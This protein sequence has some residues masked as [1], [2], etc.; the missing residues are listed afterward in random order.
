VPLLQRPANEQ[1]PQFSPDGK[2]VAYDS[3]ET[4][5]A[6]IWVVAMPPETTRIQ[7]S[8]EG[9]TQARWSRDGKELFWISASGK[10]MAAPVT[11]G[12]AF[13]HGAAKQLFPG[14]QADFVTPQLRHFA[15]QPSA[16]GKRF[17]G[18]LLAGNDERDT[19]TVVTNVLAEL[20]GR[21]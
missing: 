10:L 9:G 14:N 15:Y 19:L 11:P 17:V 1:R 20:N 4:G 21:K 13:N 6:E 8:G 3:D 5:R 16:D 2:W 18:I 7:V 12:K